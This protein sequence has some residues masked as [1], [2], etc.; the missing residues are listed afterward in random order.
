MIATSPAVTPSTRPPARRR[1]PRPRFTDAEIADILARYETETARKIASDYGCHRTT[2]EACVQRNGGAKATIGKRGTKLNAD[3]RA[4]ITANFRT[5]TLAAI[6]RHLG[7]ATKTV[8]KFARESGLSQ[9]P[10]RRVDGDRLVVD[11]TQYRIA[12]AK[13]MAQT[14]REIHQLCKA[15]A[16]ATDGV[17]LSTLALKLVRAKRW[18]PANSHVA[19]DL[20]DD[21]LFR[22][23][24]TS[25]PCEALPGSLERIEAYARRVER[26]EEIWCERDRRD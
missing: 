24:P 26:G 2:I 8:R 16:I 14:T 12:R 18:R 11:T 10:V 19:A 15:A 9:A 7:R 23:R 22:P 6:C 21:G 20:G 5:M 1:G 4:Y 17:P 3:E 13:R 25:E